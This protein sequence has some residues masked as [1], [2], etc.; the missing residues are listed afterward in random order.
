[1]LLK[2]LCTLSSV[3]P[4]TTVYSRAKLR[5]GYGLPISSSEVEAVIADAKSHP[6]KKFNGA[7]VINTDLQP[8][9][10]PVPE[11]SMSVQF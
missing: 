10:V 2:P 11:K 5:L 1:L 4:V 8:P 9:F 3:P 7:S 6:D